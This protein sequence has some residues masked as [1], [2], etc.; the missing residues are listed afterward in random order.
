MSYQQL[1]NFMKEKD[2]KELDSETSEY[3]HLWVL[4]NLSVIERCPLLRCNLKNIVTFWTKLF[5]RYSRHVC[6]WEVSLHS[7]IALLG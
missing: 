4:K 7:K 3:Q 1:H 2:K 5:I 6:Y